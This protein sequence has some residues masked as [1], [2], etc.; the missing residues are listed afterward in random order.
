MLKQLG[1]GKCTSSIGKVN[2]YLDKNYR[3]HCLVTFAFEVEEVIQE[4]LFAFPY[5]WA[6]VSVSN[7]GS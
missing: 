3:V 4:C 7:D 6:S 2:K 1:D 5:I